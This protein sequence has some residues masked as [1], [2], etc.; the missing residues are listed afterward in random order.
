MVYRWRPWEN[1]H[2]WPE[3]KYWDSTDGWK[4][5]AIMQRKRSIAWG[6]DC[7]GMVAI[8]R[9]AKEMYAMWSQKKMQLLCRVVIQ[10]E[11]WN[12]RDLAHDRILDN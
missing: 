2:C 12:T 11:A 1:E 4:A 5:L 7:E 9:E 6:W 8:R 3:E 10:S